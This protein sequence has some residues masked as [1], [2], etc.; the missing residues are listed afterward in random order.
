MKRRC[1]EKKKLTGKLCVGNI[2]TAV[3]EHVPSE[4]IYV[5]FD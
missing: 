3:E 5:Y 1:V 4:N 2:K